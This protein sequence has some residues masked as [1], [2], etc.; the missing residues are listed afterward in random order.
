MHI[1]LKKSAT[2]SAAVL[3]ASALT[4]SL[5]TPQAP[6]LLKAIDAEVRLAAAPITEDPAE[7]LAAAAGNIALFGERFA[8]S[9]VSTPQGL[10]ATEPVNLN[11][12]PLRG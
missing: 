5:V 6:G 12:A 10:L 2:T 7:A 8:S 4:L 11:E 9:F 3:A 1:G